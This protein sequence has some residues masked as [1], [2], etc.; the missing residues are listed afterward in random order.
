VR[1][2]QFPQFAA[3]HGFR[4]QPASRLTDG[5]EP[6]LASTGSGTLMSFEWD[7]DK[8]QRNL[9]K[10]GVSFDEAA[11]AFLD[12]LSITIAD[13]KHSQGEH[14]YVLLG[15]ATS[16]RTV[17]VAHADRGGSIRLINARLT[18]P[19]ERRAYEES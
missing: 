8:A 12:P 18:T 16:G 13:P 9:V 15:Q 2:A 7:D 5:D 14:R 4:A 6:L 17:V 19:R 11:T 10:H 1:R 3:F